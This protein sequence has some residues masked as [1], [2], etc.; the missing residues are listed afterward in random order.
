MQVGLNRNK[1]AEFYFF[2][3]FLMRD[4][5][6]SFDARFNTLGTDVR[7]KNGHSQVLDSYRN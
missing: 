3:F 5:S 2:I 1:K 7:V 4:R 6:M